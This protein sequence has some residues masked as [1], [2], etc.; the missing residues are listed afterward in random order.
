MQNFSSMYQPDYTERQY[1]AEMFLMCMCVCMYVCI[2]VHPLFWVCGLQHHGHHALSCQHALCLDSSE[3][4]EDVC[5]LPCAITCSMY[6]VI[7]LLSLHRFL[8]APNSS[9]VFSAG[10]APGLF[11]FGGISGLMRMRSYMGVT[12][13]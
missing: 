5:S 1:R 7:F 9:V 8:A 4:L 3:L 13:L 6:S 12:R 11:S 10:S 2:Q